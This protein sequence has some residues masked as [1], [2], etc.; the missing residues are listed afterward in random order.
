[1]WVNKKKTIDTKYS[2]EETRYSKPMDTKCSSEET[3]YTKTIK[4]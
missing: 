4:T 2:S 3:K 1:M